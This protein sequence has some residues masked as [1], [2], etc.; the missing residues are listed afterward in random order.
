MDV[1]VEN[2]GSLFLFFLLTEKAENWVN[3]NVPDGQM[4]G[5]GLAVEPRYAE[6]LA[7]GMSESGLI[8]E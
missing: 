3:E 2:H 8:I 1:S 7:C 6:N 4:L 5:N